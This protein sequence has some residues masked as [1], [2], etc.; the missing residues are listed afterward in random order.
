MRFHFP[1]APSVRSGLIGLLGFALLTLSVHGLRPDWHAAVHCGHGE[2]HGHAPG[3]GHGHGEKPGEDDPSTGVLHVCAL[4]VSAH[5]LELVAVPPA[6]LAP[7]PVWR[8]AYVRFGELL[9]W[10]PHTVRARAR[11]PPVVS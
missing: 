3:H 5:G 10:A 1:V 4:T 9:A 7:G 11:A 2:A 6:R 8:A